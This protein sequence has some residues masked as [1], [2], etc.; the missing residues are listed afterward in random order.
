MQSRAAADASDIEV[1]DHAVGL[2]VPQYAEQQLVAGRPDAAAKPF[3]KPANV[4]NA[5][6]ISP[7]A[8]YSSSGV[9]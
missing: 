4:C 5:S 2:P 8:A 7:P 9:L 3:S 1:P 6:V